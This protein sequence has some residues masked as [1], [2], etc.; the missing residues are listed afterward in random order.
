VRYAL[1]AGERMKLIE[2]TGSANP[3]G[4][5]IYRLVSS[6]TT[7]PVE[8]VSG[9]TGVP[10]ENGSSGTPMQLQV[11]RSDTS[12][13]TRVPP[14]DSDRLIKPSVWSP[15]PGTSPSEPHQPGD[16]PH[17]SRQSANSNGAPRPER[18]PEFCPAHPG[19]TTERCGDCANYRRVAAAWDRARA[20]E[21]V[22]HAKRVR[23]EVDA[24]AK[25]IEDC[26]DCDEVG[27]VSVYDDGNELG[28]RRC[29]Q[30]ALTAQVGPTSA[31]RG[32]A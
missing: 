11:A 3:K 21:A 17:T 4:A 20:E 26:T 5:A 22:A 8:S 29:E 23:A 10:V 31:K 27:H 24:E 19:G 6:S 25:R 13:G 32:T 1:D 14:T 7:M 30:P 12:S 2:Q 16:Y 18:P 9:G 28:V 15:K